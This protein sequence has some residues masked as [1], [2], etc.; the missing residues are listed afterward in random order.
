MLA[1]VLFGAVTRVAV[2]HSSL[3]ALD[4]DEAVVGL[5]ARH[6]AH[7]TAWHG[8]A[9][10]PVLFWGQNYGGIVEAIGA[11][12]LFLFVHSS[13]LVLKA[14]PLALS[15]LAAVLTWRIGRRLVGPAA[16]RYAGALFWAW[17]PAFVW[18]STKAGVY[19][20]A[21]CC[22]LA[23]VLLL[24]RLADRV[25]EEAPLDDTRE[26]L[27]FAALG[28][29]TGLAWWANPQ[30]LYLLLPAYIWFAPALG[31]RAGYLPLL[32]T[33][34]CVGAA[35]WIGF[36]LVH[37]WASLRFPHQP[38]VAGTYGR[39]LGAFFTTALPMALGWR[40]PYTKAWVLGPVGVCGYGA[41]LAGLGACLGLGAARRGQ[42][43]L[44]LLGLAAVAYP[45]LFATS[46]LS[47]YVDH[48][49]YLLFLSP[50]VA[51]VAAAGLAR[52]RFGL[53]GM[54][55][56]AALTA[57]GLV[58]MASSG[59]SAPNSPD[60]HVTASIAPLRQML[61]DYRVQDAYADYWLA[62]RT[63]FETGE[64]VL[65]APTWASRSP[66]LDAA[67]A[68][69]PHPA[70]LFVTKSATLRSFEQAAARL[71]MPIAVH[72]RGPYTVVL[73]AGR[74]LPGSVGFDWTP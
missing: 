22:T 62:Y 2:L 36:N 60:V 58:A 21:L 23:A 68:A 27:E 14:V 59:L 29:A 61:T 26:T 30:S 9:R 41:T 55:L 8:A 50:V 64:S 40:V 37:H 66:S 38:R 72:S 45:F 46:P 74:I 49:R 47:W 1:A 10:F 17:P 48:P 4:S 71:G 31:R 54:V 5:I 70:Y 56:A 3:G 18:W 11:A 33:T 73:P 57:G 13:P 32:G 69:S 16:G 20:A 42:R 7:G 28:L 53:P 35:P 25:R 39:R 44:L 15:G 43:R 65:V 6:L 24:C 19:W 51:V 12:G 34:A 52:R 67:V 63:T